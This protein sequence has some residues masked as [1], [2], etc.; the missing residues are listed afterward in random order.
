MSFRHL[1]FDTSTMSL[2]F[3]IQT[4]HFGYIAK[5][6]KLCLTDIT[7]WIH[8][9]GLYTLAFRH[10][11]LDIS[12]SRQRDIDRRLSTDFTREVNFCDFLFTFQHTDPLLKSS[13]P[14][15][16]EFAPMGSK[17]F[18]LEKTTF[19]NGGKTICLSCN[20]LSDFP[21]KYSFPLNVRFNMVMYTVS[22]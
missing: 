15:G 11:I 5:V 9:K 1:S 8:R 13:D 10:N 16:K 14:K 4:P 20:K 3:A 19:Q 7:V 17:F 22:G 6:S 21:Q 12:S 18:P 2:H